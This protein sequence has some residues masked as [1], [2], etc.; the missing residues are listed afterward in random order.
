MAFTWFALLGLVLLAILGLL[1]VGAV[2][3]VVMTT[4]RRR[5]QKNEGTDRKDSGRAT[6]AARLNGNQEKRS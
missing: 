3:V 6:P 2:I 5:D 4:T 1:A